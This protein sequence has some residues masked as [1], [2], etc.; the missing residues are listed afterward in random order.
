MRQDVRGATVR[1]AAN[2]DG[3]DKTRLGMEALL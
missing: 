3:S 2:T 1:S